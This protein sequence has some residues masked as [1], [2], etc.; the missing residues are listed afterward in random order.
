[1][2]ARLLQRLRSLWLLV[3]SERAAPREIGLAVALGVFVGSSPALGFHGW[4]AVGLA[5]LLRLNR[6]WA[7]CGSRISNM[8]T[9][10]WIAFAEVEVA[11]RARTGEWVDLE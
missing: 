4:A 2:F 1:M 3:L 7:F 10:P 9:L 11:H 6:L 8:V 5:T